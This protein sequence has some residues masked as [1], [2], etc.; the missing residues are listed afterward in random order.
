M[1]ELTERFV[2]RFP[3]GLRVRVGESARFYRRSVNSEI[4][5]RLDHSLNG[6]PNLAAEH[7]LEPPMFAIIE[8][9]LRGNLAEDEQ[10][11]VLSFRRLSA[12]K[13]KALLDLLTLG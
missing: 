10:A 6:I 4:I 1:N 12:E 8:R 3:L 2:V 13:R 5:L 9:T 7:A 11:L